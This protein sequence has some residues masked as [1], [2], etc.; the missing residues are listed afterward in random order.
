MLVSMLAG[1]P[2]RHSASVTVERLASLAGPA[3][4][5]ADSSPRMEATHVGV[6]RFE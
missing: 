5:L 2:P 3:T 6:T 4:W 1:H